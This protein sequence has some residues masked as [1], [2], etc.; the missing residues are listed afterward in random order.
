MRTPNGKENL[1]EI[2]IYFSLKKYIGAIQDTREHGKSG[3]EPSGFLK[4][5]EDGFD[6]IKWLEEHVWCYK[7]IGLLG[8]SALGINNYLLL[9]KNPPSL[10]TVVSALATQ[11]LYRYA[12]YPGGVF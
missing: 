5:G 11:D 6:I 3:G 10:K 9:S 4:E 1:R 2:G 7:N 12:A 8:E